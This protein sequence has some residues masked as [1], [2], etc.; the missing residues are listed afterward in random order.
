MEQRFLQRYY[1]IFLFLPSLYTPPPL[2]PPRFTS[3]FLNFLSTK[4]LFNIT[5]LFSIPSLFFPQVAFSHLLSFPLIIQSILFTNYNYKSLSKS[6][7]HFFFFSHTYLLYSFTLIVSL[8]SL[9]LLQI[10]CLQ[11]QKH[12]LKR[13]L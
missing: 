8:I 3:E 7:D 10:K 2:A 6:T 13:M 1:N 11:Q 5:S 9:L 4:S 12:L